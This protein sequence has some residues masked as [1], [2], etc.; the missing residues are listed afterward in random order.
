MKKVLFLYNGGSTF[1][2]KVYEINDKLFYQVDRKWMSGEWTAEE[3]RKKVAAV[4][5]DNHGEYN[6]QKI[7]AA[8][9]LIETL[10]Y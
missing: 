3:I 7:D 2:F 5:D 9:H 4:G 10:R 8:F 6:L 1:D